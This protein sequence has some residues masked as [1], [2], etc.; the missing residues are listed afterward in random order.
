MGG[1]FSRAAIAEGVAFAAL[2]DPKFKHNRLSA[3]LIMP[4]E[5]GKLAQRA[6][7][8]YI[9]RQGTR[10][11]PDFTKL[12]ER[13]SDLYGAA[14]EA[15]V[16]K[17]GS[18]QVLN[19]SLVGIDSRFAFEGED[20]VAE[21]AELMADILL[22]PYLEK[23]AFSAKETE[24]EKEYLRDSIESEI[25]DKRSYALLQTKTIMCQGEALALHKLGTVEEVAEIT[26]E[27]AYSAYCELLDKAQIE[28][29]MTGCGDAKIACE[30]F[31]K[32]FGG[33]ERHPITVDVEKCR[34]LP[35]QAEKDE[36]EEMDVKQGKLVLAFR[37]DVDGTPEER[38]ASRLMIAMLGATPTS[39]LF[40]NVR[41]KLS[42]CYYCAARLDTVTGIVFIDSG[43]EAENCAKAQE[44]ILHQIEI[45]KNGDFED[46]M[47][48]ETKLFMKTAFRATGDSLGALESW[49]LTQSLCGTCE[50]PM[51]T[52]E[53]LQQVSK[54]EV[55]AAAARLKLDTVYRLLPKAQAESEQEVEA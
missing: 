36:T 44:E 40:M 11:Y 23:G 33:M 2:Q 9:L 32:R 5:E 53:R 6:I 48:L 50:S 12:N 42:L 26:A 39:L 27:S 45:M 20:M 29:M 24:L 37:T 28:V 25:N 7:V 19:L 14:L 21:L 38:A 13:L 1:P 10:K 3:S 49:Y 55:M 34:K 47:L 17:F 43:V 4:L 51:E 31:Q 35:V 54:E 18:Y 46:K 41:E 8:P 15:S 16:D 30:T 22:D 52:M